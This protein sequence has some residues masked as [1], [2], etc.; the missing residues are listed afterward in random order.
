ML[1]PGGSGWQ[2]DSAEKILV[3]GKNKIRIGAA[4]QTEV[5]PDE[6]KK[7]SQEPATTAL[8]WHAAG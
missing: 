7:L 4:N 8:R 2:L 3:N 5:R 1:R 6:M